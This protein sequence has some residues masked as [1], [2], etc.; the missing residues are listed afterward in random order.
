[1]HPLALILRNTLTGK[2]ATVLGSLVLLCES[3]QLAELD[4]L[5][6]YCGILAGLALLIAKFK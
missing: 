4:F 1:M 6:P 2:V 5:V 3:K